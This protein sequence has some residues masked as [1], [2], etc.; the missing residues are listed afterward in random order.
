MQPTLEA[1]GQALCRLLL[2][3]SITSSWAGRLDT[4]LMCRGSPTPTWGLIWALLSGVYSFS[5][6]EPE[7]GGRPGVEGWETWAEFPAGDGTEPC[8]PARLGEPG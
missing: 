6:T 5:W 3:D 1:D 4:S 7:Q 2:L 8:C